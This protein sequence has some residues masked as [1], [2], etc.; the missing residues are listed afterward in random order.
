M[1]EERNSD[2]WLNPGQPSGHDGDREDI[3]RAKEAVNMEEAP[4][5]APPGT[6]VSPISP[7]FHYF[8]NVLLSNR[9][10]RGDSSERFEK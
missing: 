5:Q 1:D 10:Y 2:T 7:Y 9:H 6:Q 3:E 4:P 8:S